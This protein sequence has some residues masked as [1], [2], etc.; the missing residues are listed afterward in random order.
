MAEISNSYCDGN[1][2]HGYVTNIP[3]LLDLSVIESP[4]QGDPPP[5]GADK[6]YVMLLPEATYV[7][8]NGLFVLLITIIT[9]VK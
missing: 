1:G 9:P 8:Q 3:R 2:R 5:Q 6:A 7:S 4:H